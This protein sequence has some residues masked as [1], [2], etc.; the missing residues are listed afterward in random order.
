[1]DATWVTA[2]RLRFTGWGSCQEKSLGIRLLISD[3]RPHAKVLGRYL[4]GMP[5]GVVLNLGFQNWSQPC[6]N[7]LEF[8]IRAIAVHE[9]GHAIG[10]AHEQNRKDAPPECQADASGPDGDWNVTEY[11]PYSIMNY[12]NP[13]W[14]GD[15]FLSDRDLQTVQTIYGRP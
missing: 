4:D 10:F 11:D 1:V 13:K 5:N 3:E 8:C 7:Q 9:F 15:G 12:C 6:K 2:S 14:L